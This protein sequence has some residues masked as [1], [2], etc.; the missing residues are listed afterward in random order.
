MPAPFTVRRTFGSESEFRISSHAL[1]YVELQDTG[2]PVF[3]WKKFLNCYF[4]I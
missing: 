2:E 4:R 1:E 3:E